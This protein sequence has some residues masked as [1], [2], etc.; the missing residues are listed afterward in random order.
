MASRTAQI[1]IGHSDMYHGGIYPTHVM[2]LAENSRPVWLL[3]PV[4]RGLAGTASDQPDDE[5]VPAWT[6]EAVAWVPSGPEHILED[7]LLLLALHV[8]RDENLLELAESRLPELLKVGRRIDLTKMP[9]SGLDELRQRCTQIDLH[10]KLAVT[11]LEGSSIHGQLPVLERYPME[12]EV[13]TVTY[14]RLA[15][16]FAG[17]GKPE[18]R[19]S[20]TAGWPDDGPPD[21]RYYEV[22]IH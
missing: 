10:Y 6:T 12:V 17:S 22:N 20:L 1:L 18:A 14:S 4:G 16:G 9:K 15:R 19:G 13:C 3:E 5:E 21:H 11:V 7:G 8:L 2:Y